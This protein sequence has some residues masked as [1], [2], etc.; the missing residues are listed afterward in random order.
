MHKIEVKISLCA[1][2]ICIL[3]AILAFCVSKNQELSNLTIKKNEILEKK[4]NISKLSNEISKNSFNFARPLDCSFNSAD[5][6]N[7]SLKEICK[8]SEV[9]NVLFKLNIK[10]EHCCN[11]KN[12]EIKFSTKCE[13]NIYNLI[14]ELQNKFDAIIVFD[15]IKII[16][17]DKLSFVAKIQFRLLMFD[18]CMYKESI[19]IN[20]LLKNILLNKQ[21]MHLFPNDEET[22]KYTLHC[23]INNS[24]AYIN[25]VWVNI[26]D[27]LD[28]FK[29]KD[30]HQN[31]IDVY[32]NNEVINVK[33]G[34]DL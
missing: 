1:A 24:K 23:V 31:S 5:R 25:N 16:K 4:N 3:L 19:I 6:L 9:E 8:K 11:I 15:E 12:I 30:I 28:D 34:S 7:D 10:K 26:G 14:R 13:R 22:K 2:L 29:I 32:R 33:I 18:R 21:S 20:P 27:V 17:K